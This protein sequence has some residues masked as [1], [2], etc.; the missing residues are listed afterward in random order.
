[1]LE[2]IEFYMFGVAALAA[3]DTLRRAGPEIPRWLERPKG[4]SW[5]G[6][7]LTLPL[8][9]FF[10]IPVLLGHHFFINFMIGLVVPWHFFKKDEPKA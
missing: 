6:W 2:L 3:I 5:W 10:A 4:A 9:F 7:L 8:M 1:M